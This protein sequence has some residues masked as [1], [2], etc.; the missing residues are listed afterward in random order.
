MRNLLKNINF[1]FD[2]YIGY[3]LYNANTHHVWRKMILNKY[4]E[5][6]SNEIKYLNQKNNKN[7]Y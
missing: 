4:P 7:N 1:I 2:Y 3:F 5:K 6:F